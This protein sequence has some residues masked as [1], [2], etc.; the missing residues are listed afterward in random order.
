MICL[1]YNVNYI[2]QKFLDLYCLFS[3]M[4]NDFCFDTETLLT[5]TRYMKC[6]LHCGKCKEREE[7]R[8]LMGWHCFVN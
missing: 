8:R 5:P 7:T 6:R 4:S 1:Y 2:R 3:Y